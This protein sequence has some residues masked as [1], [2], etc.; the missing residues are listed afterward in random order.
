MPAFGEGLTED[1][2]WKLVAYVRSLSG[3]E[4]GSARNDE[5]QALRSGTGQGS[6]ARPPSELDALRAEEDEAL[7]SC[8]WV[9][10][11][12]GIVRIPIDRAMQLLAGPPAADR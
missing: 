10:R 1:D 7:G 3:N 11:S 4:Q 5:M 6:E 2:V 9:D 12:A 8:G